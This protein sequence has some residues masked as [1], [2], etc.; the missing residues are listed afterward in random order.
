MERM[1]YIGAAFEELIYRD[2]AYKFIASAK[3]LH[4]RGLIEEAREEANK[5]RRCIFQ[6]KAVQMEQQAFAAVEQRKGG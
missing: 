3:L 2:M 1:E 4:A 5:A 6:M